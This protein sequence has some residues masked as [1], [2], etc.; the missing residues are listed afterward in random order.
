MQAEKQ[1]ASTFRFSS[2]KTSGTSMHSHHYHSLCEIYYMASGECTYFINDDSYKISKGDVI[3]IPEGVVHKTYYDNHE[4]KRLLIE[5]STDYIPENARE[6]LSSA[7]HIKNDSEIT[8]TVHTVLLQLESEYKNHEE[9][10]LDAIDCLLKFLFYTL[11]RAKNAI[12]HEAKKTSIQKIAAFIKQNYNTPIS[13]S[14]VAA[15]N[16]IS[17]EHLSRSFKAEMGRGFS[18]YL[19]S[20]RLS[21]AQKLLEGEAELSISE[22]AYKCGFNDS[23]Y[24]SD[25]FKKHYGISPIQYKKQQK[26]NKS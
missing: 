22:I 16:F 7:I 15:K 18:E 6:A 26:A 11:A 8:S 17:P 13:L 21:E 9:Y 3:F 25:K 24:F 4:H 14:D 12:D 23:N 5:C 20:I 10:N 19:S 2:V 1:K